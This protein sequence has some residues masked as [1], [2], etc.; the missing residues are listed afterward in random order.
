MPPKERLCGIGIV[1]RPVGAQLFL[2]CDG[3]GGLQA[4]VLCVGP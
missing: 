1:L 3:L 2:P 4:P